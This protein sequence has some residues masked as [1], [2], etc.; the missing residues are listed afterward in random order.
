MELCNGVTDGLK[1]AGSSSFSDE[2]FLKLLRKA[3]SDILQTGNIN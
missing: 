3:L 1:V 2:D